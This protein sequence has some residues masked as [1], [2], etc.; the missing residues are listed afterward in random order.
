MVV[1]SMQHF[2]AAFNPMSGAVIICDTGAGHPASPLA[3]PDLSFGQVEK[4]GCCAQ[5]VEPK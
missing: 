1:K 4:V 3:P 5:P 2:R